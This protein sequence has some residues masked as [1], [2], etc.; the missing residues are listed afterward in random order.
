MLVRHDGDPEP[1]QR[2]VVS[3]DVDSLPLVAT[4]VA[5]LLGLGVGAVVGVLVVAA[6]MAGRRGP[7]A[8]RSG[9]AR[10]PG[11]AALLPHVR[12]PMALVD[13]RLRVLAV[14]PDADLVGLRTGEEVSPPPLRAAA[15]AA[16]AA[17]DGRPPVAREVLQ[18]G[19]LSPRP[20]HVEVRA[21]RLGD[22]SVLLDV[23]DRSESVRVEAVRRDFVVNVSH[24]LKT[25]VGAISVL[26]ETMV[27]ASDDPA[28]VRRFSTR[29]LQECSRLSTLVSGIIELSRVQGVDGPLRRE[30]VR[31]D[32]IA[33][34]ALD[35]VRP[36]AD[37]SSITLATGTPEGAATVEGDHDLLLTAARNLLVNAVTYSPAGTRVSCAVRR[38]EGRVDLVVTDR[39][40]GIPVPEQERVFERFYRVDPARSRATGGTG[41][42]LSIVKHIAE[43]HRGDIVLWSRPGQGSTFT[44][45]LPDPEPPAGPPARTSAH[46]P[47]GGTPAGTTT[48]GGPA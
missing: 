45:R 9:T 27:D 5:S 48:F 12:R 28:A 16:L 18:A 1:A 39:G 21:S 11:P 34:E 42:G 47:G 23:E 6:V 44:L 7:R 14:S 17:P 25:P 2:A 13:P 41:L 40:I 33:R 31:L 3:P 46:R 26:A 35:Q 43:S 30:R 4:A 22:G 36:L 19:G 8:D 10:E 20:V 37:A 38:R 32:V 29:M 24:E 15:S